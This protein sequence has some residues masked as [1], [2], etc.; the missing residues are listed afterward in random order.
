MKYVWDPRKREL[1]LKKHGVDFV[2]AIAVLEDEL[3]LT[4]SRIENGEIRFI[5]VGV[6][7][8]AGVLLVVHTEESEDVIAIISARPAEKAERRQYFEGTSYG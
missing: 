7:A 8:K 5:T 3:A 1:N 2:D 6:G 4:I